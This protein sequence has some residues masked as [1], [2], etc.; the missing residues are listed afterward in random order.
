MAAAAKEGKNNYLP[1]GVLSGRRGVVMDVSFSKPSLST[2]PSSELSSGSFSGLSKSSASGSPSL[3][4]WPSSSPS[5][6]RSSSSGPFLRLPRPKQL[7]GLRPRPLGRVVL[8]LKPFRRLWA[9]L[10]RARVRFL[11]F[12]RI[13]QLPGLRSR[14]LGLPVFRHSPLRRPRAKLGRAVR[15]L[16]WGPGLK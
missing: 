8:M 10:V 4:A 14:H 2:V 6:K 15:L 1:T 9:S 7:P 5:N 16:L 12:P 13:K 11:R 3:S